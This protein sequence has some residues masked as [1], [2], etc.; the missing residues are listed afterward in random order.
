MRKKSMKKIEM[1]K[2]SKKQLINRL[3]LLEVEKKTI[4]E[5]LKKRNISVYINNN[6]IEEAK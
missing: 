2:S 3:N 5:E 1:P 4:L 6:K